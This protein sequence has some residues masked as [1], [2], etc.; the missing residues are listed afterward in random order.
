[1][2][3]EKKITYKQLEYLLTCQKYFVWHN[4][5]ELDLQNLEIDDENNLSDS[6]WE[7]LSDFDIDQ[8]E[9]YQYIEIIK[10]GYDLVQKLFIKQI[11][12]TF[13]DKN[14][15]IINEK[16]QEQAFQKTMEILNDPKID[17]I[18]NPTFIY[19]DMISKPSIYDKTNQSLSTLL[20]SSKSKLKNYIRAY[21]DYNVCQ[22][23]NIVVNEYLFY[24]YDNTKD[25]Y[26]SNDLSFI[27]S[28]YCWTQKNGPSNGIKKTLK[29]S[30]KDTII[31]KLISG[32][33]KTINKKVIDP[34]TNKKVS[35][36]VIENSL[37]LED[38]DHYIDEIRKAHSIKKY[39][40]TSKEDLTSWG[41]NDNF[42][43]I[44]NFD[45]YNIK[46]CSGNVLSKKELLELSYSK[47]TLEDF[48][49]VNL[50]LKYILNNEI[51]IDYEICKK[52][53]IDK[54]KSSKVVWYD[55]EGFSMPYVILPHTKPYQQL[56]F[57]VS[58]IITENEEIIY[59]KNH[60]IDP[61]NISVNHFIEIIDLIYQ[62]DANHYVV[63]NKNYELS[64][65]KDM[66]NLIKYNDDKIYSQYKHKF[67]EIK[68]K[69]IDLNDL[70]MCKSKDKIPFV[71]IPDLWGFSS[72]KKIENYITNS[73]INLPIMISPYKS[74]KVQNGLMAMNKAIQRYL[75]A[76]G[77]KEWNK[78]VEDLKIYCE[79]DVKAMIMVYYFVKELLDK[80][81][82]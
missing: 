30:S 29:E 34:I 43:K 75:L 3:L 7:I 39:H 24:T 15:Y 48:V 45:K 11:Q 2:K 33:I 32:K 17:I 27:S 58:I 79:N 19:N 8:L 69:T 18:I 57:Q 52:G 49:K 13:K 36:E 37:Y 5:F 55:F 4:N 47:K 73:K 9:E 20:H 63:Y 25:Y 21:F 42:I 44:F 51:K 16:K 12:K 56:I 38:F 77:D 71:F 6:F 76:I 74:L 14:I 72:I 26:Q 10:T 61:Q 70:F 1:M 59:T 28:A 53:Y 65:I 78:V 81:K 31:N 62:Q 40:E 23:L 67:E 46:P 68:D 50:P 82:H 60:V 35:K 54:I 22:K 66:I 41:A 80:N 64:K